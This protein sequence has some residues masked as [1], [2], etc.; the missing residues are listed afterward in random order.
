[1]SVFFGLFLLGASFSSYQLIEVLY[2]FYKLYHCFITD[3]W[4][5]PKFV[6]C[7]LTFFVAS[8]MSRNQFSGHAT[9]MWDLGSLTR[10]EPKAS[11]LEEGSLNPKTA[12]KVP[13]DFNVVRYIHLFL[14][15]WL[16]HAACRI[17]VTWPGIEPVPLV[18]EAQSP[19]PWT[20]RGSPPSF[21]W[22]LGFIAPRFRNL[23]YLKNG[24]RLS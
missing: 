24:E 14:S 17:S 23:S 16:H 1:M 7:L 10:D 5:I 9:G 13:I 6:T 18:R 19:N 4:R 3:V 8:P 12:R 21:S 20:T 22:W 15:F 11:A 2:I